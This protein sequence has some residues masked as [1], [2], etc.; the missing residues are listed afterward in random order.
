MHE[1]LNIMPK[2]HL[3]EKS[4]EKKEGIYLSHKREPLG[5]AYVRGHEI[6]DRLLETGFGRWA[7]PS[8]IRFLAALPGRSSYVLSQTVLHPL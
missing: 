4:I 7:L 3:I 8:P 6:P 1:V 5:K 2:S